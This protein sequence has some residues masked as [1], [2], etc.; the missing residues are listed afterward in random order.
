[1]KTIYKYPLEIIDYQSIEI[2]LGSE[3]LTV[4]IQNEIPC[5]WAIVN[6]DFIKIK[7]TFRIFGTGNPI[8]DDFKGSYI[9]TYQSQGGKLVFHV[10]LLNKL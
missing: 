2:P 8:E 4:Q 3:I 10:F 5:I 6:P 7:Y 1:M 9:G